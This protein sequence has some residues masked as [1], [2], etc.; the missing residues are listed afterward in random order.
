MDKSKSKILELEKSLSKPDFW[1]DQERARAIS[2][3]YDFLKQEYD[4]WQNLTSEVDDLLQLAKMDEE[5][6]M[7][8]I[9][10]RLAKLESQFKK[11]EFALM[12]SGEFDKGNAIL[13][14]HSGTG[15]VD[16][17][18]WASMLLRMYLRFCEKHG[19]EAKI[20]DQTVGAE[21]GIKSVVLEIV[22]RYAYGWLRAENGVHRLVRISPFDAEKMRHT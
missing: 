15:G 5:S 11:M 9:D 3:Q 2:R 16:A 1:Q 12:F 7:A 13:S 8:E 4:L 6:L 20:I 21:A 18:D 14:I 22:G 17:Q 19:F 10:D